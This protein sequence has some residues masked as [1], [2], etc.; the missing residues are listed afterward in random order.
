[1]TA[2]GCRRASA[3][4]ACVATFGAVAQLSA[5]SPGA[6]VR[7]SPEVAVA[8]ALEH[9]PALKGARFGPELAAI[10]VGVADTA[11]TPAISAGLMNRSSQT[12]PTGAF[13][14]TLAAVRDREV[15]SQLGVGQL[16]PWGTTYQVSWNAARRSTNSFTARFLPQL[17]S[18]LTASVSQP[19]L[20]GLTFD[21]WRAARAVAMKGLDLADSTLAASVAGVVREVTHAYWQWEYA[22]E[23]LAVEQAAQRMA[24]ALRD[25][26]RARVA[27]G[28]LAAVDV[29]EAEAEVARREEA[30]I[31]A[32]KNVAN[33]EDRLRMLIVADGDA[34]MNDPF[35]AEVRLGAA[36]AMPASDVVAGALAGRQDLEAI[37]LTV[38]TDRIAVRQH[39]SDALPDVAL[40]AAYTLQAAGGTELLRQGGFTGPVIGRIDGSFAS[41]LDDLAALRYP[42]WSVQLGVSYPLGTARAEASA[43]RAMVQQR[44]REALLAAAERRVV[45]EVRAAQR[46]VDA[47]QKRLASNAATVTFAER[48]LD[49]EERKFAVGLSTSFFVFQA[50]RDL[51]L[52]REAE[53]RSMLDHRLAL[54]D[55]D[56]VQHIPLPAR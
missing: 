29:V 24:E 39:R 35:E 42:A 25:G 37:R 54:A 16:L 21:A 1:M 20:R 46:E 3:V 15:T 32:D 52:A 33:A 31:I 55:L 14:Q 36:V 49:A 11:W 8:L 13:D 10:D 18:G 30:I 22:R 26:N 47:N 50:Q 19:L 43:A 2:A 4:V 40:T 9:N 48:R 38:E 28:A 41:V 23:L 27:A 53:L 17:N 5:Q 45:T 6:V 12:Q 56:A 44:Q 34:R 7:L 51:V